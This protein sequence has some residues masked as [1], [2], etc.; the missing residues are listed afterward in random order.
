L[1]GYVGGHGTISI[2]KV[3]NTARQSATVIYLPQDFDR[4]ERI[5]PSLIGDQ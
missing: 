5:L 1:P 3:L 4:P 2:G